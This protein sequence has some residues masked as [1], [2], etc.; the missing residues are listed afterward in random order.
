M[1][2]K[3]QS[4]VS[5]GDTQADIRTELA[6][7]SEVNGYPAAHFADATCKCSGRVFRLFLD[8][9]EGAAVRECIGCKEKHPL[10]DSDEY[11]AE[12][13][14][15]ECECPCGSGAFEIT[16]GVALYTDSEDV[17]WF[18]VGCRCPSCGLTACYGDWKNE[19]IGY[20]RLLEKV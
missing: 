17:R 8:E 10:G 7:F 6:R 3:R 14:L 1:A 18:Y 13:S 15:E 5:Y 12:A 4:K 16:A 20:Q 11:L 19:F 9:N 2:L